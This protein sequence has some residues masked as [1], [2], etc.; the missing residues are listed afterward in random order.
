MH[1]A[2]AP[3]TTS[4]RAAARLGR[5]TLL[6]LCTLLLTTRATEAQD[7]Y[8]PPL[9]AYI[10]TSDLPEDLF[11]P[12][13]GE[14]P[15]ERVRVQQFLYSQISVMEPGATDPRDIGARIGGTRIRSLPHQCPR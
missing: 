8:Y 15:G 6:V 13:S 10:D 2:R 11:T 3:R 7:G 12:A 14:S 9:D 5:R 1:L 4:D